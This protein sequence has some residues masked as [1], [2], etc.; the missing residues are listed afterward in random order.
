[1]GPENRADDA[2]N[3]S[4]EFLT[5]DDP[6]AMDKA[7]VR[8]GPVDLFVNLRKA[9]DRVHRRMFRLLFFHLA[10]G[11]TYLV[12]AAAVISSPDGSGGLRELLTRLQRLSGKPRHDLKSLPRQRRELVRSIGR[13]TVTD[14]LIEITKAMRHLVKLRDAGAVELLNQRSRSFRAVELASLPAGELVS[15]AAITSHPT[16]AHAELQ[17]RLPYPAATLREYVGRVELRSGLV[18]VAESSV[19]PDTF[20]WHLATR[21]HNDHLVDV[22]EQFARLKPETSPPAHLEGSYYY[23]DYRNT[24]HYGHLMTEAIS[25]LWGWPEAKERN[26]DLRILCRRNKRLDPLR[27]T[28]RPEPGI[29]GAFGIALDDIVWVDDTVT[30]DSLISATPL[31]HNQTPF[32]AH[33]A[34]RQVWD[35]IRD[36]LLDEVE[37]APSRIFVTREGGNDP[38]PEV[39]AGLG[40]TRRCRNTADVEATFAEHGFA[41]VDPG[42]MTHAEQAATFAQAEVVAGFGGTGMFNLAFAQEVRKV[43]VLNQDSYDA[44]NEHLFATVLG[45]DCHY[46]WSPADIPQPEGGW[47]WD[48]FRSA[49]EFDFEGLG[50]ELRALL[51]SLD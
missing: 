20:K 50:P 27:E 16:S 25:R 26:P 7:L 37:P 19:L 24:G 3:A 18:A 12:P 13:I 47:S 21:L 28:G 8:V 35:R 32:Y 30:V 5:A 41:I 22:D 10:K 1:M 14:D 17:G 34:I 31:W 44:R 2:A 15:D 40:G 36:G 33:P 11:G 51:G 9:P 38:A 42:K 43:I 46:F 48:A 6:Q 4:A 29:L 49:W 39:V 23:F 45:A